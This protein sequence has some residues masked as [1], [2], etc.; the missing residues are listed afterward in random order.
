MVLTPKPI[1]L[2]V[3]ERD[4]AWGIGYFRRKEWSKDNGVWFVRLTNPT[5]RWRR[6]CSCFKSVWF[7]IFR[8]RRRKMN[9]RQC[10]ICNLNIPLGDPEARVSENVIYHAACLKRKM[11][12]LMPYAPKKPTVRVRRVGRQLRLDFNCKPLTRLVQ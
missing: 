1:V 6:E 9:E 3:R 8:K 12:E 11:K 4:W 7:A 5:R 10:P 2:R